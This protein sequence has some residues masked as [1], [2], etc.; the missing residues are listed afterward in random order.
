MIEI[1]CYVIKTGEQ[2]SKIF[3]DNIDDI[4]IIEIISN[5]NKY[6]NHAYYWAIPVFE[7][8]P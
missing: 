8:T 5:M 3:S 2:Y 7:A 1:N 6:L 4:D